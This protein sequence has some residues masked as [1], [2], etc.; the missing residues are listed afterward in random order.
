M[1]SYGFGREHGTDPDYKQQQLR[2]HS[3]HSHTRLWTSACINPIRPVP[4]SPSNLQ[5]FPQN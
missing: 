2:L 5:Y 4:L 1:C 3:F